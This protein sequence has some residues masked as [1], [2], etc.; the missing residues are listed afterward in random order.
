MFLSNQHC[1]I[2]FQFNFVL[3]VNQNCR[4]QEFSKHAKV[5]F[6]FKNLFHISLYSDL[7]SSLLL[8]VLSKSWRNCFYN[9]SVVFKLL[10]C[11]KATSPFCHSGKKENLFIVCIWAEIWKLCHNYSE[12]WA[13]SVW[14]KTL[15]F[16]QWYL[17]LMLVGFYGVQTMTSWVTSTFVAN[18]CHEGTSCLA[19]HN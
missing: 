3:C 14:M 8:L 13:I 10:T 4:W 6:I 15:I 5:C 18:S 12:S 11:P 19:L 9:S 1:V 17:K 2:H 16:L 7:S